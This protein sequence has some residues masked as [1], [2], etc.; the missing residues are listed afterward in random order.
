M[1]LKNSIK[2]TMENKMYTEEEVYEL[3]LKH[4][5]AYRSAVRN[6][7]PLDWSFDIKQW[8]ENFK[9]K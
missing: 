9:K 7:F 8:F 1:L 3:L 4:Q 2:K 5:S 6:T